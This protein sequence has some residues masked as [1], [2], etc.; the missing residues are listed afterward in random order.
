[1]VAPATAIEE[2]V[3]STWFIMG[4]QEA[5]TPRRADCVRSVDT[6]KRWKTVGSGKIGRG[7]AAIGTASERRVKRRKTLGPD[8]ASQCSVLGSWCPRS[9]WQERLGGRN[10]TPA[11]G[12]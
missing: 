1:M 3:G 11:P 2:H 4:Q 12:R 7:A 8:L 6:S 9:H 10:D 5:G